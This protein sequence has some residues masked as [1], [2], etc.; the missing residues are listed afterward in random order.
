MQ[1][2]LD[3]VDEPAV[4]GP[5]K[6]RKPAAIPQP[7]FVSRVRGALSKLDTVDLV[8]YAQLPFPQG[9]ELRASSVHR[10]TEIRAGGDI[11]VVKTCPDVQEVGCVWEAVLK[12][13]ELRRAEKMGGLTPKKHS[14]LTRSEDA[15][16]TTIF[17]KVLLNLF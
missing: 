9:G 16:L 2:F 6:R 4:L 11:S 14:P 17:V 12:K 1:T 5:K 3:M 7:Y 15:I 10:R 13:L 8:R